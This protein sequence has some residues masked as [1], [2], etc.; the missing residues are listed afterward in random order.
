[1]PLILWWT[2]SL[3]KAALPDQ[4]DP[5][6]QLKL[7][8]SL[9]VPGRLRTISCQPFSTLYNRAADAHP[10]N[11]HGA[12]HPSIDFFRN[13]QILYYSNRKF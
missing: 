11:R 2:S 6:R 13:Q 7:M 1:M 8:I 10:E 3:G 5:Q 4:R 9:H 12:S